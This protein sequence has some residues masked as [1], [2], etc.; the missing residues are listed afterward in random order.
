MQQAAK[1]GYR[2]LLFP[3]IER[4]IRSQ[5]T[6]QAV[7]QAI[8]VFAVNLRQLLLQPPVKGHVVMGLDPGYRTGCKL[9]VVD[10]TGRVLET[11]VIYPTHSQGK[12]QEAKRTVQKLCQDYHVSVIAIGN[13]TASRETERF[14]A[15]T[16]AGLRSSL[17]LI[18]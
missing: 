6:E 7:V 10:A 8:Q 14:V 18:S 17:S 2:R 5:L 3:S 9:A 1:D 11:G 4:E 13:G 15:E 16:I 12:I